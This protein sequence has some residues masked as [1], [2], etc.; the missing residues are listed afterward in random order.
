M[1]LV[2]FLMVTSSVEFIQRSFFEVFWYTHHLFFIYLITL[3]K[4]YKLICC[5][6]L[7]PEGSLVTEMTS[8]GVC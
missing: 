6:L 5:V 2:L 8:S 1:V 4:E 7:P 3:I